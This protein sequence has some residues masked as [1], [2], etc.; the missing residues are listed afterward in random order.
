MQFMRSLHQLQNI[1]TGETSLAIALRE[2]PPQKNGKM[3]EFFPSGGP[4]P[5]PPPVWEHHVCEIK[6]WFIFHFRTL[7]TFLVFTKMFTFWVVL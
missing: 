6:L 4:P 1:A 3:W 2:A 5:P 7:R